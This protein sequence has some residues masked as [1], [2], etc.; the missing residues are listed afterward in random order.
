MDDCDWLLSVEKAFDWLRIEPGVMGKFFSG[1]PCIKIELRAWA[2]F[3]NWSFTIVVCWP[4]SRLCLSH[5]WPGPDWP[6]RWRW[7]WRSGSWCPWR[8][9]W[10]G[11]GWQTPDTSQWSTSRSQ[12]Y[13]SLIPWRGLREGVKVEKKITIIIAVIFTFSREN[14][15]SQDPKC[16]NFFFYFDTFPKGHFLPFSSLW[17][18]GDH[19][20][21]FLCMGHLSWYNSRLAK[22]PWLGTFCVLGV[23]L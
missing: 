12:I 3:V 2:E 14:R 10:G 16:D 17:Y 11:R 23:L 8:P 7:R 18:K 6:R 22:G 9:R 13:S 19:N 5:R 15:E 21:F 4:V 1:T 20:R